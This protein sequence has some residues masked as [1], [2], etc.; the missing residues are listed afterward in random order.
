[1]GQTPRSTE[2]ISSFFFILGLLEAVHALRPPQ[3]A[4][5]DAPEHQEEFYFRSVVGRR[6]RRRRLRDVI[7]ASPWQPSPWQRRRRRR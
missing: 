5:Q 1:M 4:H 2:R 6:Q 3:Q 7:A